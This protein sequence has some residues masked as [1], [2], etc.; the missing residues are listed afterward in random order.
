MDSKRNNNFVLFL[1]K[2]MFLWDK[3]TGPQS[4]FLQ[5]SW[6]ISCVQPFWWGLDQKVVSVMANQCHKS[7]WQLWCE[8]MFVYTCVSD[9]CGW[10]AASYSKLIY[11]HSILKKVDSNYPNR[12]SVITRLKMSISRSQA[13]WL[14]Y[15]HA[16]RTV[17]KQP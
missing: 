10:N 5:D 17:N 8:K 11:R 16:V 15:K 14:F 1:F 3:I 4:V 12:Y 6:Q 7:F 2:K 13:S 9:V